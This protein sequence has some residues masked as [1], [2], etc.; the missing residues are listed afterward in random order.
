MKRSLLVCL[1]LF[2]SWLAS[3]ARAQEPP[4]ATPPP[5][6][7][8]AAPEDPKLEEAKRHFQQGV[9][10]YNDGN[11]SAALAE[12]EA[13]YA[14]HPTTGVLYNIGLTQKSLF[15]YGESIKTLER[16]LKEAGATLPPERKHEVEQLVAEMRALL[17]DVTLGGLPDGASVMID[18]RTI[19]TAPLPVQGIAAGNHTI[20]VTADGYVPLKKDITVAAGIPLTLKLAMKVIPRTGTVH[21]TVFQKNAKVAIDGHNLGL[22][23]VDA[24]LGIGGH[25]ME[26]SAPGWLS[27]RQEL[28]IAGGQIRNIDVFLDKP[29]HKARVYEKWWFWTL[30]VVVLGGVATAV[31]IPLTTTT[32]SPLQGTLNPFNAKV[33]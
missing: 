19:G 11:F 23:P 2:S 1:L 14:A 22:P 15:R 26:V 28:V 20:E 5:T 27:Q 8:P 3:G 24:E 17:A 6:P 13:T 30:G 21:V 7:P 18:G 10:L 29:P 33:N 16:Y 12:F 25:Q 31:A 32:Q 4:P 9:A